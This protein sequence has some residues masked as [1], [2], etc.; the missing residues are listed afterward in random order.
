MAMV[1]GTT[2]K[3]VQ[4]ICTQIP[5]LH[6][7]HYTNCQFFTG[8]IIF[9]IPKQ[10]CRS[11]EDDRYVNMWS[12][13]TL[14]VVSCAMYKKRYFFTVLLLSRVTYSLEFLIYLEK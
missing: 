2:G 12:P 7:H 4:I 11:T 8:Q 13:K 5:S 9:L 1:T 6:H 14:V 10:K 3:H